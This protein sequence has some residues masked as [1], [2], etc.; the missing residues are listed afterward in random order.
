MLDAY[1]HSATSQIHLV[2]YLVRNRKIE[3]A[4]QSLWLHSADVKADIATCN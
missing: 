1:N 3:S 2:L 4:L